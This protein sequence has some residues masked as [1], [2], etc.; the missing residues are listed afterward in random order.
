M[1]LLRNSEREAL[2]FVDQLLLRLAMACALVALVF[3]YASLT[4]FQPGRVNAVLDTVLASVHVQRE[5]ADEI[6]Q[7]VRQFAPGTAM[8]REMAGQITT[9]MG[10]DPH[11]A[12]LLASYTGAANGKV[13]LGS[14]PGQ[15]IDPKQVDAIFHSAVQRVDPQLAA[16]LR[17]VH[18]HVTPAGLAFTADEI[19][20]YG[21]AN[22]IAAHAWPWLV[23][24]ALV[25]WVLA[26]VLSRQR[27]EVVRRLGRW[28]VAVSV[29]QILFLVVG[30]WLAVRYVDAVWAAKYAAAA[31]LW[32]SLVLVPI[33]VM[34]VVGVGLTLVGRVMRD[35]ASRPDMALSAGTTPD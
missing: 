30:P 8:S 19:P 21:D 27:P 22:T 6:F 18:L 28:L 11:L 15:D 7:Q 2:G 34:G 25:L 24:L 13:A 23:V 29:V 10:N 9:E 5:T 35:R 12:Q 32:G 16:S 33:I 3:W 4:V 31:A 1:G 14:V 26:L 20:S 17:S